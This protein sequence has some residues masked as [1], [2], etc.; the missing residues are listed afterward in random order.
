MLEIIVT[1]LPHYVLPLYPAIAIL[2]AGIVDA[3]MLMRGSWMERGTA[4]WFVVPMLA[5]LAG[6]VIL[7]LVGRQFGVLVWPVV[8]A[9]TVA[10]LSAWLFYNPDSAEHSLLRASGASILTTIAIFGLVVPSLASAF[11]S[12]A[13]ARIVRA[14]SCGAS[15]SAAAAGFHEPSLVFL[16]GTGI[17]LTDGAGA[18]DFL[19]AGECRFAFVQ[20]THERSFAQRAEAIGLR[21]FPGPRIEGFNLGNGRPVTIAVYHSEGFR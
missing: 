19:R 18:A 20:S 12:A 15:V 5:G 3:R 7:L 8:F 4:W 14:G 13:L 21:Y 9:A 17:R 2:I 1:K 11:P 16:V 6:L 10:G